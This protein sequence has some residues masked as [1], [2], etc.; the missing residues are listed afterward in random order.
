MRKFGMKNLSPEEE[1]EIVEYMKD[2]PDEV[3][4]EISRG[5]LEKIR[6]SKPRKIKLVQRS[7]FGD[8]PEKVW[9]VEPV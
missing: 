3:S 5:T 6:E 7:L 9:F 4:L 8:I 2:H 1:K